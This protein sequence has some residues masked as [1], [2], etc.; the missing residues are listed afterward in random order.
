[1]SAYAPLA[2]IALRY[3]VGAGVMYGLIGAETGEYLVIDPDLTLI[4]SSVIGA[5]IEGVYAY[6]K[7]KGW[8]T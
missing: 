3:I 8:A 7:R 6:A 5:A 4:L 1:M 2:R